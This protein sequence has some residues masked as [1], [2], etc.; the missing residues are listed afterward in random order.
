VPGKMVEGHG[1]MGQVVSDVEVLRRRIA[2]LEV[3]CAA[4]RAEGQARAADEVSGASDTRARLAIESVAL[5]VSD[6]DLTTGVHN[7]DTRARELFGIGPDVPMTEELYYSRIHPDDR[8]RVRANLAAGLRPDAGG[9]VVEMRVVTEKGERWVQATTRV[10]FVDGRPVYLVGTARDITESKR[11]TEAALRKSEL[12]HR[13]LFEA[14][15]DAML[16]MEPPEW[17]FTTANRATLELFGAKNVAE[18]VPAGPSIVSPERQPNG[19]L[20]ADEAL[21]HIE[22]AMREGSDFFN[23]THRRLDGT[24]FPATVLLTKVELD[25]RAFLQ[26]TVRDMSE[27]EKTLLALRDSE[28][29][30]RTLIETTGTGYS[31]LDAEGK[32]AD[33]NQ[34]YVR[35]TG[36]RTLA[37]IKGRLVTE[38]T[39]DHDLKRNRSEVVKCLASGQVR[40]LALDYR[41]PDGH[42]IPVEINATAV[43]DAQGT[44]ILS[45]SRDVSLRRRHEE[46][47]RRSEERLSMATAAS[48]LGIWDWD[49]VAD[50]AYLDARYGDLT[51]YSGL[52]QQAGA[53]FQ[54]GIHPDDAPAAMRIMGDHLEGKSQQSIL[55]YRMRTKSGEYRWFHGLGRVVARDTNGSPLRMT[56]TILDITERKLAEEE[57][58]RALVQAQEASRA[59]SEFLANMSHETRTPMNGIIGMAGLLLDTE[60]DQEQREYAQFLDNSAQVLLTLLNDI[61]ALSEIGAG[62]LALETTT[63]DLRALIEN[64][65][66]ML[67]PMAE[68]RDLE[69][70]CAVKP[71]VPARLRGDPA[72]LRQVLLNLASNAIK[73]TDQGAVTM[74]VCPERETRAET[75]LRFSVRDTGIGIPAD[76]LGLLFQPFSQ[77]DGSPTRKY[78]GS[79]I[80]LA[81]AKQLVALMGGE[82][83]VNSVEGAGSEFW[84]TARFDKDVPCPQSIDR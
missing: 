38:W 84:F 71:G 60:L 56:G 19:N 22:T 55:E 47:I 52:V 26:T 81:I 13:L 8:A 73:F 23:W 37:E 7:W 34:E 70:A 28:E 11:E 82:I 25:G 62:K 1:M 54:S 57:L 80:G 50:N 78:G 21:M 68:A 18:F 3:E 43:R 31:I 40:H 61:L 76:K 51:G 20:S 69:L 5:G 12:W 63:F 83:G 41:G 46:A 15:R 10:S 39:A 4:L 9:V 2:E 65:T 33:A 49:M 35:L 53:F 77:V 74:R 30:F 59:K 64:L 44:R 42:I 16:T 17:L 36:R 48:G 6:F 79:G 27:T 32:V 72:R 45:L 75:V 24:D 67:G 14:S 58:R 66:A 29:K